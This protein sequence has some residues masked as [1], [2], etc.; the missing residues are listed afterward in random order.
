MDQVTCDVGTE[1]YTAEGRHLI[2]TLKDCP[3]AMLD[4]EMLLRDIC[5]RAILA[6][7]AEILQLSS[8]HFEPQG[9][10][11]LALLAESHASL[12][13]YPEVGVAFWDC[14]TCGTRCQPDKSADVLIEAFG[15]TAVEQECLVRGDGME[16]KT[17]ED[18]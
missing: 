10:T 18:G 17:V 16:N 11:V 6:T 13:T 5:R 2:L 9:V 12:H 7:G 14:F 4:D 8:H 15:A 1:A 3:P